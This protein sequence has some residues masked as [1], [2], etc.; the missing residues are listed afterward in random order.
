MLIDALTPPDYVMLLLYHAFP[1]LSLSLSFSLSLS[2]ARSL[3]RSLNLSFTH[4][5]SSLSISLTLTL[6]LTLSRSLARARALSLLQ[7][8]LTEAFKPRDNVSSSSYDMH[9]FSSSYD[10]HIQVMLTEAFKPRDNLLN[11]DGS[12]KR[13]QNVSGKAFVTA[14]RTLISDFGNVDPGFLAKVD[15][16]AKESEAVASALF[17]VNEDMDVRELQDEAFHKRSIS[18]SLLT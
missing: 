1:S 17:N 11:P 15:Q 16:I 6:T 3:A 2:L 7:V 9:V 18:V 8:M 13:K 10:I 5:H 4:S 14:M 12:A